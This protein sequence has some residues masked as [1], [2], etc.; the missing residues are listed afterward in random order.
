MDPMEETALQQMIAYTFIDWSEKR[1]KEMEYFIRKKLKL[2]VLMRWLLFYQ[3]ETRL[4]SYERFLG[5]F[6]I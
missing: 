5:Q 4:H 3:H 6:K 1:M 2:T